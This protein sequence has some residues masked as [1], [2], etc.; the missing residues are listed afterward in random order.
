MLAFAI[1]PTMVTEYAVDADGRPV[2]SLE[3]QGKIP[4]KE[5]KR[6]AKETEWCKDI[7][8]PKGTCQTPVLQF[9]DASGL[10]MIRRFQ[11][12]ERVGV[13]FSGA[14]MADSEM[15]DLRTIFPGIEV[16]EH[17]YPDRK[18]AQV[19]ILAVDG[20]RRSDCLLDGEGLVT[21]ALEAHG[22]VLVFCPLKANAAWLY[23]SVMAEHPTC[24][25]AVL[26]SL[27]EFI[28]QPWDYNPLVR[29][30]GTEARCIIAHSRGVL[31]LGVNITNVTTIVLDC[32]EVRRPSSFTP[33]TLAPE[34][35]LRMRADDH[36]SVL[37][38]NLGRA[39][40][41]ERG[42]L[43]SF[44]LLNASPELIKAILTAPAVV[45]GSERPPVIALGKD[46]KQVVDQADRWFKAGGGGIPESGVCGGKVNGRPKG[47]KVVTR[48][49]IHAQAAEAMKAGTSWRDF[50]RRYHADR[51]LDEE[52]RA[53]LQARFEAN[54]H[55]AQT[56]QGDDQVSPESGWEIPVTSTGF[57]K[58]RF[59]RR[60]NG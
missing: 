42:K 2:S 47:A 31:G 21:R 45:E 23:R 14:T 3:L 29:E 17:D 36:V 38:Q 16:R 48:E 54:S 27:D 13:V 49:S 58:R 57:R 55:V 6:S 28:R 15:S 52:E 50:A 34:D 32:Q 26:D 11:T 51:Y 59:K 7:T 44:I 24:R 19:A 60:S 12:Q 53:A 43:V 20:H 10:E 56:S 39:L 37:M 30:E 4:L 40:R 33:G 9:T 5:G 35:Y 25:L 1:N 46:V 8:F 41:G 18:I 22:G